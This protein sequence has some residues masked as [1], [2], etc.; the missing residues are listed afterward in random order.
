M[1]LAFKET[2]NDLEC[3]R[4]TRGLLEDL[5]DEFAK[6]LQDYEQEILNWSKRLRTEVV[7]DLIHHCIIYLK[8][9]WMKGCR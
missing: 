8:C 7:I 2:L 1:N 5:C 4:K 3:E 6:G 9:G